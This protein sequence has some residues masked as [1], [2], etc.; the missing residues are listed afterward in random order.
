MKALLLFLP[1]FALGQTLSKEALLLDL[2]ATK[3]LKTDAQNRVLSWT[4]QASGHENLVFEKQDEG[5]KTPLSGCPTLRTSNSSK[6]TPASLIFRQGELVCPD[7]D[8]F[9][10][11]TT[12][13][14]HTWITLL[15]VYE[16][17]VGLK[18][19][20]SFFGNLRNGGKYEG[21]WGC[22]NDDN[23][24]WFGTRNGITFGRFDPNNPKLTGPKLA[25]RRFHLVAG[26]QGAGTGKVLLELFL[27]RSDQAIATT[28]FPVNP[29]ANPSRLA[30]G[31]ERDAI[32][33]PGY[34][35]F[36]GEIARFLIWNRPLSNKELTSAFLALKKTYRLER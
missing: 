20:N 5:R 26:R 19:V 1:G 33:H 31:Q 14:G 32:E 17:R 24:L 9:D 10:S 22:L 6:G 36:D 13:K 2:D 29:K 11:L 21:L 16:Q 25:T 27:N 30:I 15:S 28:S 4:N 18:D 12:G 3:G 8:I 7:E 34:E 23:T 35:S